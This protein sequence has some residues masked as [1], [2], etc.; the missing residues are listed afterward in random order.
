MSLLFFPTENQLKYIQI[1]MVVNTKRTSQSISLIFLCK[2]L[3]LITP[4]E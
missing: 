3:N 4:D 2:G 1:Y